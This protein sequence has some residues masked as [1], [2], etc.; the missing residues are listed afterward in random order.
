MKMGGT[1]DR[2]WD[3]VEK[4]NA[5]ERAGK[6]QEAIR[7]YE[8][9]VEA[10]PF[11]PVEGLI[12]G[13]ERKASQAEGGIEIEEE[14][15]IEK[16]KFNFLS[17]SMYEETKN[18]SSKRKKRRTRIVVYSLLGL[19]I[20]GTIMFFNSDKIS[21]ISSNINKIVIQET[22]FI[23]KVGQIWWKTNIGRNELQY[24]KS[25]ATVREGQT[26]Y[27]VRYNFETDNILNKRLKKLMG[28]GFESL[29]QDM[30]DYHCIVYGNGYLL[31]NGYSIIELLNQQ[32]ER[33]VVVV[34]I[35]KNKVHTALQLKDEVKVYS[36]DKPNLH[37]QLKAYVK[38]WEKTIED[39]REREA[40]EEARK[41][42]KLD[43]VKNQY[44]E[45]VPFATVPN[46][47]LGGPSEIKYYYHLGVCL[48]VPIPFSP[49]LQDGDLEY[50][51]MVCK[52]D[53]NVAYPKDLFC[54]DAQIVTLWKSGY[55]VPPKAM[56]ISPIP[57]GSVA[58]HL[59]LVLEERRAE[60]S[61]KISYPKN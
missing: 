30:K 19:M 54:Y 14:K 41:R 32:D 31:K 47:Y 61:I 27:R 5:S 26:S 58:H 34:D 28:S 13:A 7:Y 52:N 6:Y 36:E 45:W 4:G 55:W 20:I 8:E 35:D 43:I 56:S 18:K 10:N 12:K 15:E 9:A 33:R 16:S 1:K 3:L 60:G 39:R 57:R 40:K 23:A 24:F 50:R 38:A 46:P 44:G 51:V 21:N 49:A 48:P 22:G 53:K 11:I 42:A 59:L 17:P 37:Y 2:G 25:L 29:L